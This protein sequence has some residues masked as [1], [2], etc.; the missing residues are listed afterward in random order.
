MCNTIKRPNFY[1]IGIDKGEESHV[2]GTDQVFNK[3]IEEN[4]NKLRNDIPI[5][6]Q[7]AHKHQVVRPG[8]KLPTAC[9]S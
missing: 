6:I 7:Q 3:I 8:K 2:S 5:Q 4:V 9:P 1:I